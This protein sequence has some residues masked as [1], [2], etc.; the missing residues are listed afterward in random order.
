MGSNGKRCSSFQKKFAR[1]VPVTVKTH[2]EVTDLY[3]HILKAS[4]FVI[5]AEAMQKVEKFYTG[6]GQAVKIDDWQEEM[7]RISGYVPNVDIKIVYT[8]LRNRVRSVMKSFCRTMEAPTKKTQGPYIYRENLWE[9][10]MVGCI[11][12][13]RG[14][15]KGR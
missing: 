10:N 13:D 11:K 4:R 9:L 5:Q 8:G 3:D 2:P 15:R 14:S 6:Y 1:M 7:I 12:N